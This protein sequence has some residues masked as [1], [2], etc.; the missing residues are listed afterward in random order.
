MEHDEI[1]DV[2]VILDDEHARRGPFGRGFLKRHSPQSSGGPYRAVTAFGAV[3]ELSWRSHGSA[4][5]G[6]YSLV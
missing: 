5:N 1:A 6:S 2:L 4:T 3:I